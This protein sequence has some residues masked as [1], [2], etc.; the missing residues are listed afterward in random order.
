MDLKN[1]TKPTRPAAINSTVSI[2]VILSWLM[3]FYTYFDDGHINKCQGDKPSGNYSYNIR[4]F[5]CTHA[6]GWYLAEGRTAVIF[7]SIAVLLFVL[8]VI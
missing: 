2:M 3:K 1:S 5:S 6:F 8:S 4:H 7:V